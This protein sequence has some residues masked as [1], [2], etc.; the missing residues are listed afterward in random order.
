MPAQV[1]PNRSARRLVA[2]ALMLGLSAAGLTAR[3]AYLQIFRH[4]DYSVAARGEHLDRQTVYAHRGTILDRNLNP[5]A[6]SVDTFDILID[7]EA[8]QE[9]AV[10]QQAALALAPLLGR[11]ASAIQATVSAGEG[12]VTLAQGID[13]Q[14]G[15]KIESA[16]VAGVIASPGSKRV[17]PEG[18]FA[19]SLLGFV[20]RDQTG[21]TGV[22]RDYNDVLMGK[23]G[24]LSFERDSLGNPIGF[25]TDEEVAAQSGG[26]VVLTIDRT[27]Q[28]MAEQ[29]L[30]TAIQNTHAD[31]GDIVMM[32]PQT[33]AVLALA[34]RPSFQLS[35]LDLSQNIDPSLFR[36]RAVTDMYEPGSVFKLITMGGALNEG[37]VT[38]NTTYLDLGTVT[39]GGRQFQ[40]WD[41]ST[42]GRTT[43]TEVLVKSLNLGAIWVSQ[44]LGASSFYHYVAAFGFGTPTHIGLSGEAA[45]QYR[46][47]SD[48]N[49][50][51]ADLASNSFGQGLSATPIQVL[52]AVCAIANGGKLM[53]P[54]IVQSIQD[55]GGEHVTK[56]TVVREPISEQTA[57]TLT[58]MMKAVVEGNAL[59]EVPGYTV[60][61][62]SGTAYVPTAA[63]ASSEGN[64]YRDEVT[65]PSY[66]G[67]GPIA[68][69][70]L[71]VLVKLN[72]LGTA[73]LGGEL[74]APIFS[75]LMHDGLT[76][77]HV[78]Q[79]GTL[80]QQREAGGN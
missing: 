22:E 60:A 17:Y 64:A 35:K 8:W 37:K 72:D 26:D 23:P 76:Y 59:A 31:G 43:M 7:K 58:G 54:Y 52:T 11:S 75:H 46:T 70:R 67:F 16:G 62:K 71:A 29:A 49:W 13:Y 56:P 21:L 36:L 77:L 39:V 20:G 53:R 6:I 32:D 25:G 2:I 73:D 80:A 14:T 79:D 51:L 27:L 3:L 41:F 10:A 5:L 65:I 40:N 78:P 33:G 42:N 12:D 9:P 69:P 19:S 66:L 47:P 48:P 57:A 28:T 63:V 45:G 61:G 24:T 50:S 30:D 15:R 55:A 18:D 4:A 1:G 44:V 34:S 68:H 38:P 74:T